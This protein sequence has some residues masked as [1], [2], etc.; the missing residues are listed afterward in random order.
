[1]SIVKLIFEWKTSSP[2]SIRLNTGPRCNSD[3]PL[4]VDGLECDIITLTVEVKLGHLSLVLE[5]F[6]LGYLPSQPI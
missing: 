2:I 5:I 4:N 1:M 6:S 3:M